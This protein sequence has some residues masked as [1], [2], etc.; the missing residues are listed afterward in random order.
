MPDP[1]LRTKL[2]SRITPAPNTLREYFPDLIRLLV[3]DCDMNIAVCGLGTPRVTSTCPLPRSRFVLRLALT[4][5]SP[6]VLGLRRPDDIRRLH[7]VCQPRAQAERSECSF[8]REQ[9]FILPCREHTQLI[10]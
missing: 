5:L 1:D 6:Q 2:L 9:L 7:L 3:Q 4:E 10:Q 8:L